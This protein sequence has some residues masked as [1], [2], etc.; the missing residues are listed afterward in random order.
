M[1]VEPGFGGQEFMTDCVKKLEYYRSL[2]FTNIYLEVD[3][4]INDTTSKL[5]IQGGANVLVAG[6]YVYRAADTKSHKLIEEMLTSVKNILNP[7]L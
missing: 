2:N 1:T 7:L 6:N 5:A 3:G 4:G